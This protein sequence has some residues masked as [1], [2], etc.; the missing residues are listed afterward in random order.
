MRGV[1]KT[2]ALL[3]KDIIVHI[4]ALGTWVKFLTSSMNSKNKYELDEI[5]KFICFYI[6]NILI[7][8]NRLIKF[9][10]S[11]TKINGFLSYSNKNW[12]TWPE[13]WNKNLIIRIITRSIA[14]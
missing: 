1:I 4:P 10:Q 13:T 5:N 3:L 14:T 11:V 9:Q 6:L 12:R 7:S 2:T 8:G